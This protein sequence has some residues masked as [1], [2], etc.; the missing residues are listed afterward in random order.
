MLWEGQ[1]IR[2]GHVWVL[3]S[4]DSPTPNSTTNQPCQCPILMSSP[5]EPEDDCSPHQHLTA[6]SIWPQ[7]HKR[8]QERPRQPTELCAIATHYPFKPLNCAVLLHSNRLKK[9]I[10]GG[11]SFSPQIILLRKFSYS[12][13]FVFSPFSW[14]TALKRLLALGMI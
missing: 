6:A 13:S 9:Q 14:K 11:I 7:P 3:R 10:C 4:R 5:V 2:R 8:P 12:P 1:A